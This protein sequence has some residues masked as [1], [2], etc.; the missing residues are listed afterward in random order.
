MF[1]LAWYEA[2]CYAL[3]SLSLLASLS[4][5]LTREGA[6]RFDDN[7]IFYS[8]ISSHND[9]SVGGG[10]KRFRPKGH[11]SG[12]QI[13]RCCWVPLGH[14][15]WLLLTRSLSL[16]TLSGFLAWDVVDW[17]A[18]IFVYYTEWTFA[19]VM[20]YF[21]LGVMMSAYGCWVYS[22]QTYSSENRATDPLLRNDLEDNRYSIV[23][24]NYE[25]GIMEATGKRARSRYTEEDILQRAGFWGYL[26]QIAYQTSAGA[27][28][29]TDIVFWCIIVP[30]LPTERLGLNLLMGSMHT[31]NLFFLLVD[32][33]LNSLSFPW[34]RLSYFV[35]W[36]CTYVIFQWVIHACGFSWW[37]YPFL[38][39][40]SPWSAVWYLA[41]A[42]AHVPCYGLYAIIVKA[43]NSAFSRL[44]PDS[45]VR[46]LGNSFDFIL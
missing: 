14:P 42:G 22:R 1:G 35:L 32:T 31:L 41:M 17:D 13:W 12:S 25:V 37:P 8:L 9:D 33:S 44:F 36:S 21:G 39:V 34:F 16:A 27:V 46:S 23:S 15:G 19:L 4:V 43:K 18:S 7:A 29:L 40:T 3:V 5:I 28:I 11:V 38:Q 30:F 6:S 20:V 26:M 24:S 10:G 45:F 2:A